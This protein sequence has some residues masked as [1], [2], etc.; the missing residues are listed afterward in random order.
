[1][2]DN[3]S[4]YLSGLLLRSIASSPVI[5]AGC[6][7]GSSFRLRTTRGLFT[8][9]WPNTTKAGVLLVSRNSISTN[10]REAG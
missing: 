7:C 4:T 1:M 3:Y 8:L 5:L 10:K 2:A 6:C 9:T